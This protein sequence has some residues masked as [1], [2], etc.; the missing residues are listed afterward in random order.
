LPHYFD[1]A[2]IDKYVL[3]CHSMELLFHFNQYHKYIF[4]WEGIWLCYLKPLST[5]FQLYNRP[6]IEKYT[7]DIGWS[8][9]TTPCCDITEHIYQCVINFKTFARCK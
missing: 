4:Q 3:W 7:Y 2:H 5:I 9:I 8:E 6:V 1:L